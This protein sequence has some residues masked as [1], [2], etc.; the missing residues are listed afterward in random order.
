MSM[1]YESETGCCP[2]FDPEPW[3]E[4]ELVW[5]D[6]LFIKDRVLCFFNIPLN[7]G[8]VIVRNLPK[9]E[10]A[11]AFPP[12]PVGLSE[13]TSKWNMDLYI[14]VSREVPDAENVRLSGTYLSKVFEGPYNQTG[15]W[16]KQMQ[17]WVKTKGKEIKRWFM[18]YTTCPRCAKHYGKNYVVILTEV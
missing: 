4:K 14:E 1:P 6:R 18:F 7:F 8:K 2:R 17:E 11:E 5:Q 10:K 16:C 9:I 3:D 15:K 13:H 12:V